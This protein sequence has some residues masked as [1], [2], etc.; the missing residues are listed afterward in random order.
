MKIQKELYN[1]KVVSIVSRFKTKQYLETTCF[2]SNCKCAGNF[3]FWCSIEDIFKN[4]SILKLFL[5]EIQEIWDEGELGEFSIELENDTFIGWESTSP[6]ENYGS[7][8]LEEFKIKKNISAV[9][10][11][12]ERIH[13]KAPK[14]KLVTFVLEI[15]KEF[16][17]PT[18]IIHSIYP[19]VDIGPLN[20]K[21]ITEREGRL[22]FDWNHPGE[23]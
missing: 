22:F 19:G 20:D 15:K 3:I 17:N 18:V 16:D 1:G 12:T 14:T 10:I 4:T 11:K 13:L 21:N 7:E 6:I 8:D 2:R 23:E 9:R 5:E